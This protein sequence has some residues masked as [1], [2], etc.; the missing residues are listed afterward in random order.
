MTYSR[1]SGS[2]CDPMSLSVWIRLRQ[3]GLHSPILLEPSSIQKRQHKNPQSVQRT[4]FLLNGILATLIQLLD[5]RVFK[6]LYVGKYLIATIITKVNGGISHNI[7][8]A[9]CIE[10]FSTY[11]ARLDALEIRIL[12]RLL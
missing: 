1:V 4:S 8:G 7:R 2:S 3:S 5:L 6:P 12:I 10:L 11:S 9:Y